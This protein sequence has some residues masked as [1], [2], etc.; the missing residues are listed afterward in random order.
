MGATADP[1]G[2][3]HG[4]H[5]ED[6]AAGAGVMPLSFRMRLALQWNVAFGTLLGVACLVIYASIRAFLIAD[7]D[8]NLRTLAATEV[9]SSTDGEGGRAHLHEFAPD[10]SNSEFSQKF[11]QL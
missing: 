9:A 2:P 6:V 10:P 4:V 1:H 5:V 3:R 11:V 7:V 8:A